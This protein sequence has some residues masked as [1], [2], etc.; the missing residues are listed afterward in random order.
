[1]S[2][3]FACVEN[4]MLEA[5]ISADAEYVLTWPFFNSKI[6]GSS[7]KR[8]SCL[9]FFFFFFPLQCQWI[10][11]WMCS[12]NYVMPF[13]RILSTVLPNIFFYFLFKLQQLW[14]Q[15]GAWVWCFIGIWGTGMH[16]IS[17]I[18]IFWRSYFASPFCFAVK[19][20]W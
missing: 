8:C 16:L 19:E 4:K 3:L 7:F 20:H 14:Y 17:N 12:W 10:V 1:M 18:Q 6:L 2:E 13:A 5:G 9:G 11:F 15:Q